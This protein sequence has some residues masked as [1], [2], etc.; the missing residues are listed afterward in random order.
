MLN[1]T[2]KFVFTQEEM[3]EDEEGF[4]DEKVNAGAL[5]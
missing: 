2:R 1:L 5:G 4:G 3:N